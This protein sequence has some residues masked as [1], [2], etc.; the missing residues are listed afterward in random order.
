MRVEI[1]E[2]EQQRQ[3]GLMGRTSLDDDSG[4]LFT[5][6]QDTDTSFWMK[7]TPL[8]LT[9]AFISS[10]GE[11]VRVFDMEPCAADPCPIYDPRLSYRMALEVKQGTLERLGVRTG[12]R[13]R[14]VR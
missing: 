13:V 8:P 1:A 6:P 4:M 5:W 7:D 2:T 14:L 11:I 12:D 9:I 3:R 10:D